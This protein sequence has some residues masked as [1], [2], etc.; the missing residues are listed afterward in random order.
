MLGSLLIQ[1]PRYFGLQAQQQLS[2]GQAFTQQGEGSNTE[3]YYQRPTLFSSR[4]F[5][6]IDDRISGK[7]RKA[8]SSF[9]KEFGREIDI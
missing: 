1:S 9:K 3:F 6:E 5:P 7:I 4:Y 8:I 2:L